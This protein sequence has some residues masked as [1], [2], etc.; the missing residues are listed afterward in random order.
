MEVFAVWIGRLP[1]IVG[2]GFA[3]IEARPV[4]AGSKKRSGEVL[5]IV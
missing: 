2:A 1:T 5:V 3:E 4:E